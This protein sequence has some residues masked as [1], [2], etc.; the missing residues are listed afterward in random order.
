SGFSGLNNI[1]P[2]DIESITVLRD[3]DATSIYGSQGANGVILITT[4]KGSPGKTRFN[5]TI[6]TGPNKITRRQQFLN[7]QQYL[8]LRREG[9]E[10]DGI[11]RPPV[12]NG[13]HPDLLAFDTT[14]YTDWFDR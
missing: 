7:T 9:L 2:S 11:V 6:N 13:E 4:K 8:E 14:K 3:A 5:A 10:N 12:F 1:N